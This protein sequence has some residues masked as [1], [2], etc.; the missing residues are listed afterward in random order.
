MESVYCAVRAECLNKIYG[1]FSE[2]FGFPL[3][4]VFPAMLDP[5]VA[6]GSK[7][8][9]AKGG[10]RLKRNAVPDIGEHGT[11]KYFCFFF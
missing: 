1:V 8:K 2:Y 5:H 10:N 3:P 4:F 9:W 11:E 7:D 6:L